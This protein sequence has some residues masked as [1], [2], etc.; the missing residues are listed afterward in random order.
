METQFYVVV[1]NDISHLLIQSAQFFHPR[2]AFSAP[3]SLSHVLIYDDY[4]LACAKLRRW[5]F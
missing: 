5:K 1:A 4:T 3:I 2:I